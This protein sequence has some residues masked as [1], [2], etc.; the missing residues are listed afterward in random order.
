MSC[1]HSP[2][3]DQ[4]SKAALGIEERE[5]SAQCWGDMKRETQPSATAGQWDK[6]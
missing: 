4:S 2:R 1:S 5:V 6:D 3:G